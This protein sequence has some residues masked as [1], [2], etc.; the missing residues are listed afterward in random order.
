M[1]PDKTVLSLLLFGAG[2]LALHA[3]GCEV[4]ADFDRGKLLVDAGDV[5]AAPLVDATTA[6]DANTA[7]DG[8]TSGD[9]NTGDG[10]AIPDAGADA[11]A[12]PT[13]ATGIA[14][15]N[16]PSDCASQTTA[17]I[18]NTCAAS[19][20][21][22]S[23]AASG[24]ACT[25]TGGKLCDGAG[26]C[27]ACLQ[28]TD[29]PTQ[30]TACKANACDGVAHTCSTT[31]TSSGTTCTD[32]GGKL[33][34]GTGTCVACLQ[35]SDCP[36]QTTVCKVNACNAA[37]ACGTTNAVLGTDCTDGSGVVCDG[38]GTCV[39][40]HCNDGVKDAD[41]TDTDCGGSC[42]ATC[43]DTGP[44]QKCKV[45]GD[46]ISGVCSGT[47]LV[48]QPPACNDGV[49]NG[50]ETD[51]DCGGGTCPKCADQLRCGLNT[52]CANDFCFGTGPGTCVSCA[53]GLL[54]GNET[55]KDCGGPQCDAQGKTCGAGLACG[56]QGDCT[57][58][59]GCTGSTYTSPTTCSTNVCVAGT[60]TSCAATG[61]VCDA[62][63]GCVACNVAADC[64][65]TGNI[66]ILATC[67]GHV[68]GTVNVAA[69]TSPPG[70]PQTSGDCQ[71]IACNGAGAVTFIDDPAD[72]PVG[73]TV[74]LTNPACTGVPLAP[75]FTPAPTGT[76]CTADNQPPNHVCADTASPL[77]GKC[78]ECNVPADC[79][80]GTCT[81]NHTCQ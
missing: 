45:A 48:C 67:S 19:C 30:T 77:A 63:T 64:V 55:A 11:D 5:D 79:A 56:V 52:D 4:I 33:C 40:T 28:P 8:N 13:C 24:T 54:D 75:S 23:N 62:A 39:A 31:N 37:H 36:V 38:N 41:E 60:Q 32:N 12:G 50:A 81:V 9:G 34:D 1:P 18:T 49:R 59:S 57:N 58:Q 47:P 17:C 68:C 25:D 66:C 2:A 51:K 69:G 20:C 7:G 14:T 22:T 70:L 73:A 10:S 6:A 15:C 78:V 46:C 76:D 26:N 71:R 72:L 27:A 74:C 65:P 29:C 16:A 43:K 53:D 3:T 80:V 42:G 61:K 35:P 21:G 44:Q